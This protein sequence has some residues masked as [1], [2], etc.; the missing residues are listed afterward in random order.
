MTFWVRNEGAQKERKSCRHFFYSDSYVNFI[1]LW[2]LRLMLTHYRR[3]R[4]GNVNSTVAYTISGWEREQ[5]ATQKCRQILEWKR[6]R[7]RKRETKTERPRCACAGGK[8]ISSDAFNWSLSIL[9]S[10]SLLVEGDDKKW[11]E[12]DSFMSPNARFN[13]SRFS[14]PLIIVSHPPVNDEWG[15][16]IAK[17]RRRQRV[18]D[19]MSFG[20][21][22]H[23][24]LSWSIS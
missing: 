22:V 21:S 6:K 20:L 2:Q 3:E 14:L 16:N 5:I 11:I 23:F 8:K 18:G 7:E 13:G 17:C 12:K 24:S 4:E 1:P 9:S 15:E 10:H 19:S